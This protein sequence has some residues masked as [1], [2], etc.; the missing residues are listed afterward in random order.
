MHKEGDRAG[1][2]LRRPTETTCQSGRQSGVISKRG[3]AADRTTVKQPTKRRHLLIES[4]DA[5]NK[6]S[7]KATDKTALSLERKLPSDKQSSQIHYLSRESDEATDRATEKAVISLGRKLQNN[8]RVT[9]KTADKASSSLQKKRRGN[10]KS[11]QQS[12]I[13]AASSLERERQ[14][15]FFSLVKTTTRL[16]EQPN[17]WRHLYG[18]GD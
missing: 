3:E 5:T 13:Q 1:S 14:S 6:E 15:G 7:V 9:D 11:N 17:Q 8:D 2:F 12:G 16:A 18:E 4:D 10:R